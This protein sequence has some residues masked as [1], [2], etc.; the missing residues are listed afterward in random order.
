MS[1]GSF[2]ATL[3]TTPP[4]SVTQLYSPQPA[5]PGSVGVCL[6]GGGSRALT[7]GMGELQALSYLTV[8]GSSMLGQVKALSTVSGGSWLGVPFTF[9]P[10]NGPTDSSFLGAYN[11]NIGSAT[12][13]DLGSL[14]AGNAAT[15]ITDTLIPFLPVLWALEAYLLYA[16]L[17]VPEDMLWQTIIGLLILDPQNLYRPGADLLPTDLFSYDSQTLSADVTGPNPPLA[18][19]PAFRVASAG[20]RTPR[21]FLVCNMSMFLNEPNT[22]VKSLAPV[23]ATP[24]ITGIMG[25]PGGTDQ[26]G[27]QPGGGG[28][29]SFAF[30]SD[31]TAVSGTSVTV[32]QTRQWSLTDITGTSSAFFAEILQ[33]QIAQWE[34]DPKEFFATLLDWSEE[35]LAWIEKHLPSDKGELVKQFVIKNAALASV[36]LVSAESFSFS[37][38]DLQDII[39][40]YNY[41][42]V[43]NPTIVS[44][45][46]PTGF[47]DGGSLENCGINA[48]LAYSDISS[49]ISFVNSEQPLAMGDYGVQDG[50]GFVPN[51][52]I[53]V[54]DAIPPLF[55]YQPYGYGTID[56]CNKG[57]VL[58]AGAK[59]VD[60]DNAAYSVNQVF[61]SSAFPTLLQGLW[62]AANNGG[63]N[64]APAIWAQSLTVLANNWFGI[65]G[66]NQV[67][68]VWCYLNYAQA[69]ANQF[70]NTDVINFIATDK[71]QNSFPNYSTVFGTSLSPAQVNLMSNLAA[72]AVVTAENASHTFSNLFTPVMA[73]KQSA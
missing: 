71:T 69:W 25:S 62:N 58:Y 7:A 11:L 13:A 67:T 19:D 4:L 26:N 6:S 12:L 48:L 20:T 50:T 2:K 17:E 68:V 27:L 5:P 10:N 21:P 39:P 32:S 41:W 47:A 70:T 46:Q 55:G 33:D 38:P 40:Q 18:N 31:L 61:E 54:D 45:P 3:T 66:G 29:T 44:N 72:W 28:V 49:L 60:D 57:Y 56:E 65:K 35:I 64:A 9:L 34:Q 51:T 24:F 37:F 23:Q 59:C 73:R 36:P 15:P 43:A 42:P 1:A 14:P 53:I 30:N 16:V 22:K 63:S 52:C 8:N